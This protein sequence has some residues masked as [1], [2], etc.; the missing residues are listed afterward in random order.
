MWGYV[1]KRLFTSNNILCAGKLA[2]TFRRPTAR[3]GRESGGRGWSEDGRIPGDGSLDRSTWVSIDCQTRNREWRE[4]DCSQFALYATEPAGKLREQDAP[5]RGPKGVSDASLVRDFARCCARC[6]VQN[7]GSMRMER[8]SIIY[9]DVKDHI[10]GRFIRCR[11]CA[12]VRGF[13]QRAPRWRIYSYTV[14]VVLKFFMFS[15]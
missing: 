8:V 10:R 13:A 6:V 2:E 7:G 15:L 12:T 3:G 5:P 1:T 11:R 9:C 4:H 14:L